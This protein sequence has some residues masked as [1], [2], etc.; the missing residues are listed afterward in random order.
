MFYGCVILPLS[1]EHQC[2][3]LPQLIVNHCLHEM[4]IQILGMLP[5]KSAVH[6]DDVDFG[7]SL[8]FLARFIALNR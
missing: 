6:S 5:L 8:L 1:P 2:I 3:E 4:S 7:G